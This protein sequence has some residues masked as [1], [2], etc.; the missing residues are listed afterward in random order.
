MPKRSIA[1]VLAAHTPELMRIPGVLGTGE[2][3][4]RGKPAILVLVERVTPEVEARVPATIEGYPVEL[5][6][7]GSVSALPESSGS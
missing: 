4:Q 6:E 1:D 7:T 3:V 2:G 5:H